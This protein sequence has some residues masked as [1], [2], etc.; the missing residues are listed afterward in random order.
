LA[1]VKGACD[2]GDGEHD[3]GLREADRDPERGEGAPEEAEPSERREEPDP[4]DRGRQHERELDERDRERA[5]AEAPAR[6]QIGRRR[7]DEQDQ[8]LCDA[9]RL[10]S[11]D[12]RVDHDPAAEL[13]E[14]LADGDAQEDRR[15]RQEQERERERRGEHEAPGEQPASDHRSTI[16]E[17]DFTIAV[18]PAPGF[19]PSSSAA[20]LV[21][22]ATTRAGPLTSISTRARKPSTSTPRTMPRK[23]LRA[24]RSSGPRPCRRCTSETGTIRRFAA[25]R[26]VVIRPVR[27][28]LRRV[29]RLMP[30]TRTASL[31]AYT[32]SFATSA[33][34]PLPAE[35]K[36]PTICSA[37][38]FLS[39]PRPPVKEESDAV[40]GPSAPR[41][42]ARRRRPARRSCRGR[43][44]GRVGLGPE[45]RQR[46]ARRFRGG[47]AHGR[48]PEAQPARRVLLR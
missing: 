44:D 32:G 14:E 22:I 5:A 6:D 23:R 37:E 20:S 33:P 28:H 17:V 36:P 48:P 4:R 13:V 24:L 41:R 35:A 39:I 38:A 46:Q 1:Q 19:R 8:P 43:C 16:T 18:A 30:R 21:M 40:L 47:V 31:A 27:S 7:A 42:A 15:E 11:D 26:Y 9:V 25:S 3:C 45:R 2:V 12:D 29:S 10:R 34:P